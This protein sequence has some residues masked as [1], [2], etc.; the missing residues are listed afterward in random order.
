MLC[1]INIKRII[2][3]ILLFFPKTYNYFFDIRN[4]YLV[5]FYFKRVQE[6]DFEGFR[7]F[8][9][10]S[11]QLFLDIGANCG[12]SALSIFVI[13]PNARVISFEPNPAHYGY[14]QKIAL[15]FDRFEYL[16]YGLGNE[17]RLLDF[18]YPTYNGRKMTALCSFNPDSS[19]KWLNKSN[20]AFFDQNKVSLEKLQAE[21]RRLDELKLEPDF[22]KIDV[23]G[24]E[25]QVLQGA[26]ETINRC[27]PIILSEGIWP[28]NE[29]YEFLK[30]HQY[31]IFKFLD[32]RFYY[33][34]FD[35]ANKF[36]IPNEKIY[37]IQ[38]YVVMP[39]NRPG[40]L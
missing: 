15:K 17:N 3:G 31:S 10:E 36:I 28:D 4:K 34:D 7:F 5:N 2:Q 25:Y 33:E 18:Y 16:K 22:I 12:T 9:K 32:G 40:Q 8:I 27:R 23:E 26:K 24:F 38:E 35:A 37:M 1:F 39:E 14:L 21:V 13:K 30:N 19:K 20:I 11:S 6:K 29:A